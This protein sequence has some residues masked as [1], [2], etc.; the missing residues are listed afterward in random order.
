L[1]CRGALAKGFSRVITDG[2]KASDK[3]HKVANK[4][5]TSSGDCNDVTKAAFD[6]KGKYSGD[7]TKAGTTISA[8]CLPGD[9]VLTNFD[10][11]S[12]TGAVNPFID[13]TIGGNSLLVL[14][15]V[16]LGG[17]K[18]KAKCLDTIAKMRTGIVR[19]VIKASTK[20]Q[21][22]IDKPAT[23]FGALDPDCLDG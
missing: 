20:C 9:P 12:P 5:G 21:A 4:A 17:D 3:C 13:D 19:D 18:A 15:N 7:K 1:K 14:G 16:D 22:I 11:G 10:G 23:S 8:A 6:P 2:Y